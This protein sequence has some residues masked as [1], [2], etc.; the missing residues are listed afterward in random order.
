MVAAPWMLALPVTF[1]GPWTSAASLPGCTFLMASAGPEA[2]CPSTLAAC[3]SA[4][5]DSTLRAVMDE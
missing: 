2:H 5:P 1:I 3:S 4:A